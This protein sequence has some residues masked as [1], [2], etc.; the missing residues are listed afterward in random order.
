MNKTLKKLMGGLLCAVFV[1]GST[2]MSACKPQGDNNNDDPVNS[3]MTQLYV[4]VYDGGFGSDFVYEFKE[5]FEELYKDYE[6]ADGTKG[7]QIRIRADKNYELTTMSSGVEGWDRDIYFSAASWDYNKLAKQGAFLDITDVVTENLPDEGTS[8][9]GKMKDSY[10]DWYCIDGKYYGVPQ[11]EAGS[12]LNYDVDMFNNNKLYISKANEND[13]NL[14]KKFSCGEN[15]EGRAYGPDGVQGTYDDG[16]PATYDDFFDL[17]DR[18]VQLGITPVLWAGKLQAYMSSFLMNVYADYEGAANIKTHFDFAGDTKIIESFNA[19]GTPVIVDKTITTATNGYDVFKQPGI[20]YALE[21]LYKIMEN[22]NYYNYTDCLGGAVDHLGSQEKFLFGDL[23]NDPIGILIE[24]PWWYNEAK[25][26]REDLQEEFP[27][28][29]HRYAVM[30]MPK[31]PGCETTKVTVLDAVS[32]CTFINAKINKN[33]VDIA[34]KFVQFCL[35]NKNLSKFTRSTSTTCPYEYTMSAEDLAKTSHLGKQMYAL[36]S[37][38]DYCMPY[39]QCATFL[40]TPSVA[41]PGGFWQCLTSGV[42]SM[43]FQNQIESNN[44]LTARGYFESM[45]QYFKAKWSTMAK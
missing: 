21:F 35:T 36:H 33:K 31:A 7:V 40:G 15:D 42:P 12:G 2:V 16:L 44:G 29:E 19:D 9:A 1:F 3:E 6:F 39:S 17:L 38:A 45:G 23:L 30:P 8:I 13:T 24:G 41:T 34:K 37:S 4:G 27:G 10:R 14:S 32:S 18:M 28:Q 25:G 11:Y 20:Y 22:S 26:A 43:S 5:E